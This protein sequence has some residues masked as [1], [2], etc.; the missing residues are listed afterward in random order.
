V[1]SGV[2]TGDGALDG[3]TGVRAGSVA[4]V[5]G[6]PGAGPAVAELP[7]ERKSS[8]PPAPSPKSAMSPR[9]A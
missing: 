2:T 5:I 7:E 6:A 9:T 4:D 3:A 1:G 8:A